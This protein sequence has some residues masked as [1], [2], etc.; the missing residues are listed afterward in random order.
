MLFNIPAPDN[1]S[2][3]EEVLRTTYD[4]DEVAL[5]A[6]QLEAQEPGK[7]RDLIVSTARVSLAQIKGGLWPGRDPV[8]LL[9]ILKQFGDGSAN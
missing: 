9:R 4:P 2:L 6:R 7:Y 1:V 3:Q 5:L 8:P